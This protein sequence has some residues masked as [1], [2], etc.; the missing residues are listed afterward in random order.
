MPLTVRSR[1]RLLPL[2][3]LVLTLLAAVALPLGALT[4]P[5]SAQQA[6]SVTWNAIDV[7]LELHENGVIGVTERDAII[8]RGGPFQTGFRE[9]PLARIEDVENITVGEVMF[10]EVTPY[11]WVS[12]RDFSRDVPN[13]YTYEEVGG[14]LRI[15]WS[16]PPTRNGGRTFQLGF[17]ALGALRVYDTAETPYQQIDW[18]GVGREITSN[19]PVNNAS[20]TIILPRAVDPGRVFIGG[21]GDGQPEDHTTDG[22]KTWVWEARNLGQG[23]Q[24]TGSLQFEPLV[25]AQQP[26]WQ[27]AIDS[28]D[29]LEAQRAEQGKLWTL[30]FVAAGFLIALGGIPLILAA[31][32]TK[33]RD[34]VTGP[35]AAFLPE[36]PDD[37]PPGIV[38]ALLDEDV[39]ERDIVATM[40]DLG[41]RHILRI[42]RKEGAGFLRRGGDF[43][44]TMLDP[45]A[46]MRPF[47]KDLLHALFGSRLE[48]GDEVQLSDVKARFAAAQEE[49]RQKMYDELVS[50]GFFRRPPQSTR[51]Q[52]K[53]IGTFLF[54]L[55]LVG[56]G[57]AITMFSGRAS[58]AWFPV[59]ALIFI[60][61]LIMLVSRFMP[62]KTQAGAEAAAK[63]RA[64][65]AYLESIERYEK[66]DQAQN[67]FDEF[68]PYAIA[69]GL[70]RSWVSKFSG[71]QTAAPEWYG[72]GG[73]GPWM[74]DPWPGGST[75]RYPSGRGYY[76][77]GGGTVIVPTGGGWGDITGGDRGASS[78]GGGWSA[79]DF[80]NFSD[81]AAQSLQSSS[82]SLFDLFNT[83]G[84]AFSGDWSGSGGGSGSSGGGWRGGS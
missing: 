17:D 75:R 42:D 5:A 7:T 40:V 84:Q 81:S 10:G 4:P 74:G 79:P 16:F 14:K 33:G 26:S 36:P 69:L 63:W 19:A 73:V 61:V 80:Q 38:G 1:W 78:G 62:Q 34:P 30:A 39:D 55:A 41:R 82:G 57:I 22:G 9:I 58:G 65:K 72:G 50:R 51:D 76:P 11:T 68:L 32:W 49:I 21:S 23:D 64:F 48:A 45:E 13:T 37:T 47:E 24:F 71:V 18:I 66:L 2:L 28:E 27:Q 59:A 83:A 35:V 46:S 53:S 31:W 3:A 29:A 25:N 77:H 12:K 52:W 60:A 44:L 56:G 15:D 43:T 67:I 8:F 54:I 20:L 70:E 6:R